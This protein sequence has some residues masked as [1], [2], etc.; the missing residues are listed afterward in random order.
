MKSKLFIV[1]LI[2]FLLE[3]KLGFEVFTPIALSLIIFSI[4][5][6]LKQ[7][8]NFAKFGDISYGIYIFHLPILKTAVYLNVYNRNNPYLIATILIIIVLFVGF[9][10]WHLLEKRFLNRRRIK[11]YEDSK[12][13]LSK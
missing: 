1:G 2:V 11:F 7:L 6:S 5:F 9:L 12:T 3:Q 13:Y 4:A 10:S 8:N